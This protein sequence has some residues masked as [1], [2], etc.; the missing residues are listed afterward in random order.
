MN[1]FRVLWDNMR[2]KWAE[3]DISA[4]LTVM[5]YFGAA[6]FALGMLSYIRPDSVGIA[7]WELFRESL[8]ALVQ[9]VFTTFGVWWLVTKIPQVKRVVLPGK[10]NAEAAQ[11]MLEDNP[12]LYKEFPTLVGQLHLS[13]AVRG[14][15]RILFIGLVFCVSLLVYAPL[16]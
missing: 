11:R 5:I 6:M 7:A 8:T 15:A 12:F 4:L 14:A 3:W 9:A 2:D 13:L 10:N 1:G 16:T